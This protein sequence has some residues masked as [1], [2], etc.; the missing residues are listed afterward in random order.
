ML[1]QG[2][3]KGDDEFDVKLKVDTEN[4]RFFGVLIFLFGIACLGVYYAL[5]LIK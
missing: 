2:H 4:D 5:A 1:L 3:K